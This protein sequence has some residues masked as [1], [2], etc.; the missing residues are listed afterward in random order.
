MIQDDHRRLLNVFDEVL[1]IVG[2]GRVKNEWNSVDELLQNI[3]KIQRRQMYSDNYNEVINILRR[4]MKIV[5]ESKMTKKSVHEDQ[6]SLVNLLM[7]SGKA[8]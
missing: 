2:E 8:L 7:G 3:A 6:T 4:S 1:K 5:R